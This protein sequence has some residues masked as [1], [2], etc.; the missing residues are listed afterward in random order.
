MTEHTSDAFNNCNDILPMNRS[1]VLFGLFITTL[2]LNKIRIIHTN[3]LCPSAFQYL[4]YEKD[5]I[6]LPSSFGI[7]ATTYNI[8]PLT[9]SHVKEKDRIHTTHIV[10]DSMFEERMNRAAYAERSEL[11]MVCVSIITACSYVLG[12][13]NMYNMCLLLLT[14]MISTISADCIMISTYGKQIYGIDTISKT[15]TDNLAPPAVDS[16]PENMFFPFQGLT[17]DTRSETIYIAEAA[18]TGNDIHDFDNRI[19]QFQPYSFIKNNTIPTVPQDILFNSMNNNLYYGDDNGNIFEVD[20]VTFAATQTADHSDGFSFS[21][22]ILSK[23]GTRLFHIDNRCRVYEITEF[24]TTTTSSYNL[25]LDSPQCPE[26]TSAAG[27]ATLAWVDQNTSNDL[28]YA[29][30]VFSGDTIW[31]ID[32]STGEFV[33]SFN[34]TP[35]LQAISYGDDWIRGMD[36]SY[37][38]TCDEFIQNSAIPTPKPSTLSTITSIP[39]TIGPT[40][41]PT[42]NPTDFPNSDSTSTP[43]TSN[44]LNTTMATYNSTIE[45]IL[46]TNTSGP[47]MSI[48]TTDD[49]QSI[50]PTNMWTRWNSMEMLVI[51]GAA[52]VLILVIVIFI[53]IKVKRMN[54]DENEVS[55]AL[56]ALIVIAE[57]DDASIEND[58]VDV[59]QPLKSL[60]IEKD[61]QHLTHLFTSMNYKIIPSYEDTKLHWKAEELVSFLQNDV[62]RELF[63]ENEELKYDGLIV[64]VSSH[65]IKDNI[66]TSDYKTIEKVALHRLVSIKYPISRDIPRLFLFDSCEG[67]GERITDEYKIEIE[68]D[69]VKGFRLSDVQGGDEWTTHTK[70]PDYK[71]V[72]IHAANAGFQAKAHMQFGSYLIYLFTKKMKSN[73][74]RNENKT[75]ATL[76][77]EIQ[78]EL[79]DAGKSQTKNVFNN[80]TAKLRF[81]KRSKEKRHC[82]CYYEQEEGEQEEEQKEVAEVNERNVN[83]NDEEDIL[84]EE[85]VDEV[86]ET[87]A[88][89]AVDDHGMVE[90]IN[91]TNLSNEAVDDEFSVSYNGNAFLDFADDNDDDM[92]RYVN[93]TPL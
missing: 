27:P 83:G 10:L 61:V 24:D 74:E 16:S 65:G 46:H 78:N 84:D 54:Q 41:Y 62:G 63:D 73:I 7:L 44:I 52:L 30:F 31:T 14:A 64:V 35:P 42:I 8:I 36:V 11:R 1:R 39:P 3:A 59:L 70:N 58:D 77:D 75:L 13:R 5:I 92:V 82:C 68:T 93:K 89:Q 43:S 80:T 86:N 60:P 18:N 79:H 56:V 90:I 29:A 91:E 33:P 19:L 34:F 76:F 20:T 72:E 45:N 53:C 85:M 47:R 28:M 25:I 50:S 81:M 88:Y 38:K 87:Y 66:I 57:Y 23:D 6:T 37:G 12:Y 55:N 22:L 49:T 21:S 71:L 32:F 9:K 40:S 67:S 48:E 51:F 15:R 69:Q 17:I 4:S 26:G 2:W